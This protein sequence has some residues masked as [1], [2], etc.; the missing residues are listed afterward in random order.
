MTFVYYE[1]INRQADIV[2]EP[3]GC[4]DFYTFR[5]LLY[6]SY[7]WDKVMKYYFKEHALPYIRLA[8]VN[9][10]FVKRIKIKLS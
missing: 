9:I 6:E 7:K 1:D 4:K 3:E 8:G 10:A 5:T 2:D